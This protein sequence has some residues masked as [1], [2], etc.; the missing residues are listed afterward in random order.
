MQKMTGVTV[1][2]PQDLLIASKEDSR[3]FKRRVLL[4]T[5]GSLY[6][7]GKISAGIAAQVL[8]CDKW[9]FYR[10]LSESGFSVIDYDETEFADEARSSR[11][12]AE[13]IKSK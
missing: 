4:Q 8:G 12:L 9:E 10:L 7:E 6:A 13:K 3:Q 5:L 1:T 2:F 11:E